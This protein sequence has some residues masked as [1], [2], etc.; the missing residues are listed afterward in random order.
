MPHEVEFSCTIQEGAIPDEMRPTLADGLRRV[1]ADVLGADKDAVQV[2]FREVARGY[3]FRGGEPS[4]TSMVRGTVH[5]S[6]EQ[7]TR[8]EYLQR[9]C[10]MWQEITGCSTDEL[11]ASVPDRQ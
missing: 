5:P 10:D 1:S 3:G 8:V 2:T 7:P 6:L 4:T 11:V 9:I